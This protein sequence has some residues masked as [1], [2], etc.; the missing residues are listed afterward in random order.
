MQMG[1]RLIPI[2]CLVVIAITAATC[3]VAGAQSEQP[4][5]VSAEAEIPEEVVSYS[6]DFFQRYQP[7]SAL[8]MVLRVPGFQIDDG[9]NKRGFG[10]ASGNILINDR[11]P[12]AKQDEASRILER[13]PASQVERIDLIRGQ[14]RGIDLRSKSAVVSVMLR[15]DIPATARW[16][17]RL[18]KNFTHS[19]VTARASVSL[20]DTWRSVEY[21]AGL[22]YRRFRSGE[23]GI[24]D[25]FDASDLLLEARDEDTFRRGNSGFLNLN[26]L[27][28]FGETLVNVNA[29]LGAVEAEDTL[30]S[31][32]ATDA[33]EL[34]SDDFFVDDTDEFEFEVGA[35]AE[36][37]L[38]QDLLGK[39]V[40][41]YSREDEDLVSTQNRF[42]S[43]GAQEFT[44][45]A[46]SNVVQSEAIVRFE[47]DW[48]G[49]QDHAVKF[50]I[51]A[52]RNVID[53]ELVQI[54]DMGS[55]PVEVPVPGANTRVEED[56]IEFLLIDTWFRNAVEIDYGF[57]GE[58]STIRQ[59]GDAT[60]KRSFTFLKPTFSVSYSPTQR[61]Q[62][63]VRIAREV[64]QLR[65]ED[66]VS[67]TDFQNDDL[68]LGNP[69]LEPE[70]T[71]VAEL[72][73]ER[74]FGELGVIKATLF[75]DWIS[76][77]E[78]LLPLNPD[79][80]VPG[81]IGD[82][83]RWG[84][85]FE[86]TMSLEALGLTGARLD[87]EARVQDSDVTDPVTGDGRELSGRSN[88]GKPLALDDEN[89]YAFAVDFRQDFETARVAWGWDVRKRDQR[90]AYRV[91][92]LVEYEE[93][94]E[95]NMFAE[96]TRWWGLKIRLAA[97]NLTNF[98]QLRY[99]TIYDG[100]R[101][102][103]PVDVVQ[104]QDRTDGRRVL[105]TISGSF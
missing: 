5:L 82:G 13:I 18:R 84:L 58:T 47:F 21:N 74:R 34:Q 26:M 24:E 85:K 92:E 14:V 9:D 6:A 68:A 48:T 57:G 32:T 104:V 77:V 73:E 87:I 30:D 38:S 67:T 16:E 54:V 96:T 98:N 78:D 65:F 86:A 89:R 88:V 93:G 36:R 59:T 66:F 40:L 52:A 61:R 37:R 91:N 8:D 42:A 27:T 69:D 103:V 94:T 23:A 62:T 44:R 63:R 17:A 80:E 51:E 19:P 75:H 76:D 105:L 41:L 28:W 46:E 15:D 101:E 35:D 31:V 64:S 2:R 49:W 83:T 29:Q 1:I 4:T 25:V 102:L 56:R 12:S 79:F 97:R 50:D 3:P 60:N 90:F 81:N 100:E 71:W 43:D 33:P 99:R 11:Y 7:N 72:S 39:A 20:S 22:V 53:G 70:S 55:G 45:V 10:A 95:F